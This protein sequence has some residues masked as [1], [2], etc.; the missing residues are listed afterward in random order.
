MQVKMPRLFSVERF[1]M[2]LVHSL[3]FFY[4]F[5]F[6]VFSTVELARCECIGANFYYNINEPEHDTRFV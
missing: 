2:E 1:G 3:F 5:F 6:R 4:L